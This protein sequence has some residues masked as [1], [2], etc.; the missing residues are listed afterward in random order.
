MR[1]SNDPEHLTT[2][3]TLKAAQS[4]SHAHNQ[5]AVYVAEMVKVSREEILTGFSNFLDGLGEEEL[6]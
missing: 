4:K 5:T 3:R 1:A 6:A 2:S